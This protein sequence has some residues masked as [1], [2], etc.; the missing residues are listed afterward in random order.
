MRSERKF[1]Y[2]QGFYANTAMRMSLGSVSNSPSII[3]TPGQGD[4]LDNLALACFHCNRRKSDKTDVFDESTGKSIRLFNPRLDK[5]SD[6]F[7]W[8][9][10]GILIVPKSQ[11]GRA[12]T[13]LLN[14]NRPRILRIREADISAARHPPVEDV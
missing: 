14:H 8:S 11:I 1:G 3:S 12:T 4:G 7:E 6:H 5:W 13:D 10:Y 9:E 2:A